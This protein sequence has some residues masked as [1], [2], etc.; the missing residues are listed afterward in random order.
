[1]FIYYLLLV[2]MIYI[3]IYIGVCVWVGGRAGMLVCVRKCVCVGLYIY[4]YHCLAETCQ[5]EKEQ[6]IRSALCFIILFQ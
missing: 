2:F 6:M 1:M 5:I 3:C 4:I